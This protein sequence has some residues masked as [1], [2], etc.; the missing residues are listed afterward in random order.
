M[1]GG[2]GGRGGRGCGGRSGGG[3]NHYQG[4]QLYK[5]GH[6]GRGARG[7]RGSSDKC[8]RLNYHVNPPH[9]I[10]WVGYKFYEPDFYAKFLA[11]QKTRLHELRN[12]RSATPPA[13]QKLASVE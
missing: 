2:K 4:K 7:G 3:G 13:T 1:T 10:D 8:V 6:G 11:E 5:G 9:G 12:N